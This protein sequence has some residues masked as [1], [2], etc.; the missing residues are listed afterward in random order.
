M[1]GTTYTGTVKSFNPH[2]GWGFADCPALG[3]DAFILKSEL[4]GYAVSKNDQISF[5]VT[6]GPKGMQATNVKI[7]GT[8]TSFFGE[9]KTWNT[10]KGFGF[11]S[12]P[13]CQAIFGKDVFALRGEFR[14]GFAMQGLQ[15]QFKAS[16]GERGPVASNIQVLSPEKSMPMAQWGG[17]APAWGGPMMG[18]WGGGQFGGWN[19]KSKEEEEVYFGTLKGINAEKGWGHVSCESVQKTMGKD[20]FIM[21]TSLEN[22]N[23]H[24][25]QPVSFN[26]AQGPKGPHAVNLKPFD[27]HSS[28][29]VFTGKI[30][31]FNDIKGWGFIESAQAQPIFFSDIFV[32]KREMNGK[33][34]SAGDVVQFTVD[35]SGGRAAAQNVTTG[36]GSRAPGPARAF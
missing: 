34:V 24:P 33:T 30:K 8:P 26:I 18:Q 4:N 19:N 12:S 16:M 23:L 10:A 36:G 31:S 15:V 9:V 11:L 32:H 27:A 35:V 13:A 29:M 21:K 6:Q 1:A 22:T 2:K 25:G 17:P 20:L 3:T 5:S 14:D 28:G 7:S